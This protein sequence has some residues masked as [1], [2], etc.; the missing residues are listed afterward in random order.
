MATH[1]NITHEYYHT[2]PPSLEIWETLWEEN[3]WRMWYKK[4]YSEFYNQEIVDEIEA[5]A[6]KNGNTPAYQALLY[7]KEL[8]ESYITGGPGF[9]H[10]VKSDGKA[11]SIRAFIRIP[12]FMEEIDT[13]AAIVPDYK[14]DTCATVMNMNMTDPDGSSTW[15][16]MLYDV[17][18]FADELAKV[19]TIE[20][21]SHIAGVCDDGGCKRWYGIP[22][23]KI[24][25]AYI[26]R[27]NT[28]GWVMQGGHTPE[29]IADNSTPLYYFGPFGWPEDAGT[30]GE[31]E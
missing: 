13:I 18:G 8:Y 27:G 20:T 14:K 16:D 28:A 21:R 4:S 5:E 3:Q 17:E 9:F 10:V 24:Q 6:E 22:T 25:K 2:T 31:P 7:I 26:I 11:I 30:I 12:F 29:K 15:V 19:P 23:G 1:Q